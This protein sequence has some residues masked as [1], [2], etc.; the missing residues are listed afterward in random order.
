ME[1]P[2]ELKIG[3][4]HRAAREESRHSRHEPGLCR[5]GWSVTAIDTSRHAV[6]KVRR[7]ATKAG[8]DVN[9]LRED[10]TAL[11]YED[12]F[13]LV[14]VCYMHLPPADRSKSRGVSAPEGTSTM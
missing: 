10:V 9:A 4:C 3:D 14:S 8:L 11:T 2:V 13:E 12:E 6:S 1:L 7:L 5:K